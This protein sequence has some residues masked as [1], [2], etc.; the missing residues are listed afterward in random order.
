MNRAPLDATG[1]RVDHRLLATEK[2]MRRALLCLSLVLSAPVLAH[3]PARQAAQSTAHNPLDCWCLAK[4]RKFAPGETICLRTAEGGRMAECRME[5]NVMS[6][7]VT[8]RSCP[9]T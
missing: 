8:E 3:Q 2:P 5:V 7:T 4:G 1:L 6:W 9:E